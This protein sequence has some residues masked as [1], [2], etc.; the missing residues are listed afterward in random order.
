MTVM[1]N[2]DQLKFE[3]NPRLSAKF[4]LLWD[5]IFGR[6]APLG[7]EIGCGNGDFLV[8]WGKTNPHWNFIGIERSLASVK[9]IL[10]RIQQAG[11]DNIRVIRDDARFLLR[12]LWLDESV[13]FIVI[14]FPDP[15][16][17]EKHKIRRV[18][19]F[20]FAKSV[21]AVLEMKGSFEIV[22]DQEWYAREASNIF[23]E[24][25]AF[26]ISDLELNPERDLETKYEKKWRQEY[27][28]IFRLQAK[29]MRNI[30][31]KRW[32]ESDKMPHAIL[33]K[34]IHPQDVFTLEGLEKKSEEMLFK[35]K[36][37][38]I[39]KDGKAFVLRTIT[40]DRDYRQDF[41]L[42]IAPHGEGSII[43][44]DSVFQ[45]Y[46]TPAVKMAVLEIAKTIEQ[47]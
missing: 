4:P 43:K 46:R 41:F 27:R 11:L 44:I 33:L 10:S 17:K 16:P 24:T 36:E 20:E 26:E 38:F 45:P 8:S 40:K 22:T 32:L 12:E 2:I 25:R 35:I 42:I 21:A 18:I 28:E 9:R 34:E 29:K 19:S 47:F 1:K 13:R 37:I 7:I 3:L 5:E 14:N 39:S 31:I 23:K 15:W 30:K 6:S